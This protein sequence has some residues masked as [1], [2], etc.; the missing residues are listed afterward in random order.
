MVEGV[1]GSTGDR[2]VD[3][4]GAELGRERQRAKGGRPSPDVSRRKRR[5]VEV[6]EPAEP[7]HGRV[8]V[9]DAETSPGQ[10]AAK[11]GAGVGSSRKQPD[12][13]FVRAARGRLRT[14]PRHPRA[15]L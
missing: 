6:A 3:A 5:V 1:Q 13:G 12:A 9:L 11:L 7:G 15:T 4:P 14:P 10:L 8:D 2:P